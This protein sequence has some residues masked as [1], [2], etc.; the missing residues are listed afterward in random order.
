[1]TTS[2]IHQIR[3]EGRALGLT[4]GQDWGRQLAMCS[5]DE[6][7]EQGKRESE[8]QVAGRIKWAFLKGVALALAVALVAGCFL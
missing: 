5:Y 8:E 1:M 4:Q 7:H 6:G 2:I 3:E